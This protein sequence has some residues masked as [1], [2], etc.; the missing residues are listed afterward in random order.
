MKK[1]HQC[2]GSIKKVVGQVS[3]EG[4]TIND[5]IFEECQ[6]CHEQY[7]DEETSIFIQDVLEFVKQQRKR[8]LIKQSA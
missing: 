8:L 6:Q 7:F 5:I 4:I 3:L 1:C 2:G